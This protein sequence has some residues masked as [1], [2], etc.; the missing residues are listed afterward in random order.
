MNVVAGVSLHVYSNTLFPIRRSTTSHIFQS[1]TEINFHDFV[2]NRVAKL[3]LFSLEQGQVPRHSAAH[4]H[5]KLKG[6]TPW[7]F[8]LIFCDLCAYL[9]V[10]L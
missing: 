4:P 9:Q 7:V 3:C 2:W 6:V 10:D 5:R 8:S 1:G